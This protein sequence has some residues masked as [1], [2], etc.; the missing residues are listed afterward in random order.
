MHGQKIVKEIELINNLSVI[1][2]KLAKK[3][4]VLNDKKKVNKSNKALLIIFPQ[5]FLI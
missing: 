3:N 1:N 2:E 5:V 4:E